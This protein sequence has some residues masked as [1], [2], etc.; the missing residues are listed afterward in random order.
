MVEASSSSSPPEGS[1]TRALDASLAALV[2]EAPA[3]SRALAQA[4]GDT[5]VRLAVD[6]ETVV[7]AAQDGRLT[8]GLHPGE[9]PEVVRAGTSR[10]AILGL[11]D[12]RD[13]LPQAILEERLTLKG[14]LLRLASAQEALLVY[15]HGVLRSS[16][17]AAILARWRDE[18]P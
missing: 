14:E 15:L 11:V 13:S 18:E 10:D 9:G 1:F 6:R 4:L 16:S 12:G 17:Q 8:R 2:T 7:L 5:V 3:A